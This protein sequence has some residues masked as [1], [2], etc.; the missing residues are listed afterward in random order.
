M[1]IALGVFRRL[2]RRLPAIL[3]C[4]IQPV[5]IANGVAGF[6]ATHNA[7]IDVC[8]KASRAAR[9]RYRHF[10]GHQHSAGEMFGG[11]GVAGT[12]NKGMLQLE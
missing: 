5:Q 6:A 4:H 11:C 8:A 12:A 7:T 1:G 9:Q 3:G 2:K 10:P